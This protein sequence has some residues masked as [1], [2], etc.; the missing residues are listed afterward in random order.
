VTESTDSRPDAAT[1][2][3]TQPTD[4]TELFTNDEAASNVHQHLCLYQQHELLVSTAFPQQLLE[5]DNVLPDIINTEEATV[6]N[7]VNKI[8]Q[9]VVSQE[10]MNASEDLPI[11][12]LS[13][14]FLAYSSTQK[15]GPKGSSE[16][17]YCI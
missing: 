15:M 3:T 8:L 4:A 17:C 12:P 5:E 14:P 1:P 6:S 9:H 7:F 10:D 11:S 16:H 13:V 2:N